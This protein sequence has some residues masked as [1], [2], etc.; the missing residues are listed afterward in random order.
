MVRLVLLS[1]WP[2]GDARIVAAFLAGLAVWLSTHD[3]TLRRLRPVRQRLGGPRRWSL[4][5]ALELVSR[6]EAARRL[7]VAEGVPLVCDLLAVAVEA[8]RPVR[9]ALKVVAD[10]CPEPS[11][12]VLWSIANRVDLGVAED[13]AWAVLGEQ[14]GYRAAARDIARSLRSGV[15]LGERL[16]THARDARARVAADARARA[17]R[18]SVAA[19]VPLVACFL[20]A[21]LLVGV[22]PIFGG[23]VAR[24]TG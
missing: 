6:G 15:A 10:A 8:G 18:V 21:F 11:R 1:F 23:L 16:R 24:F 17:R 4:P 19:V 22:V 9:A 14:P 7:A 20:P 2:V 13:Q 12:E 5:A 3:R